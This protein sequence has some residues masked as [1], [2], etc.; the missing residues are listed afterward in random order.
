MKNLNELN[1]KIKEMTN[2]L[3]KFS[4]E[5]KS[6]KMDLYGNMDSGH[7]YCPPLG[8]P[9]MKYKIKEITNKNDKRF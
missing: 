8:I 6:G 4:K 7:N 5:V 2:K 3:D 9:D 1:F